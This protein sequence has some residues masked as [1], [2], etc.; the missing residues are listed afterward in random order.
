ME[1]FQTY[2]VEPL[3]Y[4]GGYNPINTLF[5]ALCFVI[6]TITAFHLFKRL[7]CMKE[8]RRLF[9]PWIFV[10]GI[11]RPL[12]DVGVV[13]RSLWVVT[14]GIYFTIIIACLLSILIGKT[15]GETE[16]ISSS[17]GWAVAV[18]LSLNLLPLSMEPF[19]ETFRILVPSVLGVIAVS[20]LFSQRWLWS[21]YNIWIWTGHLFEAASTSAGLAVGLIEQHVIAGWMAG[22]WGGSGVVVLKMAALPI[23]IWL[24]EGVEEEEI[25]IFTQTFVF[26]V[27][28]G[29]GLRNLLLAA[30][31]A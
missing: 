3:L 23:I 25:R 26:A 14:P 27:G 4:G 9:L 20:T 17:I 12:V 1:L 7:V 24:L 19:L 2:V 29:P 31:V 18:W 13:E 28:A 5:L 11:L 22:V 10:G 16:V 30:M 21:N 6:F 15:V 8:F